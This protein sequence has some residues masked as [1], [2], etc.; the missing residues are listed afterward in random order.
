[1]IKLKK[2]LK[3]GSSNLNNLIRGLEILMNYDAYAFIPKNQ[4][5]E[6]YVDST[7]LGEDINHPDVKK[8]YYYNWDYN[9]NNSSWEFYIGDR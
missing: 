8:M 7:L 4:S 6:L 2:N 5:S 1:M 9:T 3:E